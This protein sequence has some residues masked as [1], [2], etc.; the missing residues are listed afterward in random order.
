MVLK[1]L[2]IVLD[3]QKYYFR[4]CLVLKVLINLVWTDFIWSE[5]IYIMNKL[6]NSF[7]FS[8]LIKTTRKPNKFI[9]CF[10]LGS[11]VYAFDKV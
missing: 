10:L 5:L 8:N 9:L 2:A 4:L 7:Y 6:H 11:S 1:A 3:L